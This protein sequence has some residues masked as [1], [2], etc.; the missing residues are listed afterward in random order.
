MEATEVLMLMLSK[1]L[2]KK[3]EVVVRERVSRNVCV[4]C[5]IKPIWRDGNCVSCDHEIQVE[6]FNMPAAKR[7]VYMNRLYASGLRLRPY[8]IRKYRKP[9]SVLSKKAIG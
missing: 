5:G 7:P 8:E 1:K 9:I 3:I 6:L 2:P 4:C